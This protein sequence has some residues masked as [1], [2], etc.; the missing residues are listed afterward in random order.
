MSGVLAA[1]WPSVRGRGAR[2]RHTHTHTH[3]WLCEGVGG[4]EEGR[5]WGVGVAGW[6]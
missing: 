2:G 6:G 1:G 5:G 4:G 3:G